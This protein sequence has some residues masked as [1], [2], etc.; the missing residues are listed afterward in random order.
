[1]QVEIPVAK[2]TTSSTLKIVD[3]II[4][5]VRIVFTVTFKIATVPP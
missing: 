4:A 5:L 1:M 2:E 3:D